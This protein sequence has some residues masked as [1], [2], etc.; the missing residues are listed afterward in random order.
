MKILYDHQMFLKQKYGGITKYFCELMKNLPEGNSYDLSVLFADNQHLKDYN[1]K[2]VNFPLPQNDFRGKGRIKTSF[3]NINRSYSKFKIFSN[4][5]DI[6]HPTYYDPYFLRGLKKPYVITVHDL[7]EF[8]FRSQYETESLIPAMTKIISEASRIISISENT[9][10]D[11][12]E[13]LRIPEEKI[14][15][16]YHGYN[17]PEVRYP[18]S[19]LG[20]YILYVGVRRGYKNFSKLAKAFRELSRQDRD[21][22]LVCAGQP[23]I[24]EE[25]EELKRLQIVQKTFVFGASEQRLNEL[26]S[27]AL[28]FVY[29]T[30]YEGFGMPVLEAFSNNCAVCVS[31]TSSLPEVAGDAAEYFDPTNQDSILDA[32]KKVVYD[33][34]HRQKVVEEGKKQL[35]K[36]SW[37]KCA[38][39]TV[40]TYERALA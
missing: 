24:R 20:R 15:V 26:Y 23:F 5:Y 16:I 34:K 12:I 22:K 9:K 39:Q 7:I 30:L 32:I 37:E 13:M 18:Q 17:A 4:S 2:K 38:A 10:K 19:D 36:F 28:A 1:F 6:F 25:L 11:L 14:D 35:K 21:L 31:S 40:E 3:Y 8:K 33:E 27:N 29:P